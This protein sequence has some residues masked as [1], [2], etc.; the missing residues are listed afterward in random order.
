MSNETW[1][2]ARSA[3]VKVVSA[4]GTRVATIRLLT[5]DGPG[6]CAAIV[7][8]LP[9][10]VPLVHDIWSGRIVLGFLD[11]QV[12]LPPE[13][14]LTY[15]PIPGDVYYYYRAPRY[16]SSDPF[17]RRASAEI[18]FVY[19]RDSRP[20]GPRGPESVNLFGHID[21]D[22]DVFED[23]CTRMIQTGATTVTLVLDEDN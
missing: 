2:E 15:L 23:F 13:N 5:E 11:P 8:L 4:S 18:G 22:L 20:S 16:V 1:P 10:E 14:L 17:G 19:G 21:S 7:D 3:R 6:T 9:L 12:V